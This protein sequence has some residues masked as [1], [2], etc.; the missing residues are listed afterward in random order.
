MILKLISSILIT[1]VLVLL[2]VIDYISTFSL[3]FE[4]DIKLNKGKSSLKKRKSEKKDS[5][6]CFI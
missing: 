5:K 6:N 1:A 3:L 2:F 4:D